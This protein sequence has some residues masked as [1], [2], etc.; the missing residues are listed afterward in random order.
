MDKNEL[1]KALTPNLFDVVKILLTAAVI[2]VVTKLQLVSDKL[3]ALLIALP[4]TSILAMI[5]MRHESK[6]SDEAA[7]VESIA[8][9]AYY[10]FWFV[11]PTM[12]MFLVIPWMLKK[13][14]G[15]YFTLGINA[16]MTT[17]LFWLLVITLKKFTSIELM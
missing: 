6:V 10:T 3:S 1:L 17:A 9:H 4:L 13:G 2:L 8:N 15:F 12:P 7:R 5:W 14:Y 11:L 16:V